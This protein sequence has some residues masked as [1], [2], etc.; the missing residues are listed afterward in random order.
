MKLL[1]RLTKCSALNLLK[2]SNVHC[3]QNRTY[4]VES[5]VLRGPRK[6][7]EYIVARP[8]PLYLFES[9][10][11]SPLPC[12]RLGEVSAPQHL[13]RMSTHRL[14]YFSTSTDAKPATQ[15]EVDCKDNKT[16]NGKKPMRIPSEDIQRLV[17]L[18][19]P[20]RYRLTSM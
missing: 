18:M 12:I 4:W 7:R 11:M 2:R 1:F 10:V 13:W 19:H 16:K 3:C 14:S 15:D 6:R 17:Q 9:M 20:E 8:M 5:T